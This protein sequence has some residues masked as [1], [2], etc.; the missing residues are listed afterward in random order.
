M[1]TCRR[2]EEHL[3]PRAVLLP[4]RRKFKVFCFGV[5]SWE[6]LDIDI[7][8]TFHIRGL[9]F[10]VI[11]FLPCQWSL[12][13]SHFELITEITTPREVFSRISFTMPKRK[14]DVDATDDPNV[15]ASVGESKRLQDLAFDHGVRVL[16]SQR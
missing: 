2:Q 6:A 4:H 9:K 14:H 8:D 11:P 16:P 3:R 12:E 15:L 7:H 13:Q 10:F 5:R 1:I